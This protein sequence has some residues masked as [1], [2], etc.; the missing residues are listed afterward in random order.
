MK[1]IIVDDEKLAIKQFELES[2]GIKDVEIVGRFLNPGDALE[3]AKDHPVEAAL[4]DIEMPGMNGIIFGRKLREI[5]PNLV[6]IFITGYEKYVLE[7]FKMKADYYLMKPYNREDIID[8]IQR[9]KLLSK[10][11]KKR[12]YIRTFGRF[13]VFIDEKV[14]YLSNAKAKELLALCVD[15]K[16]GN[17]TIEEAIDKLWEERVYDERVKNLYRKAVMCLKQMFK[18]HGL[19]DVF[20]SNRG[21]CNIAYEKVDCDYYELLEGRADKDKMIMGHYLSEYSWAEETVAQLEMSMWK[22]RG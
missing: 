2:E 9:A 13:D 16:G 3:Y 5:Y 7:A 14:V 11:Q 20:I 18:E 1:T 15:H 17:V 4:L 21:A 10:R 22:N 8:I 12:V 6:I 19:E